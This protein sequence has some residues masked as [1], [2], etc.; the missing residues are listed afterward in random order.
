VQNRISS[1]IRLMLD[2]RV[3]WSAATLLRALSHPHADRADDVAEA[4]AVRD[5]RALLERF[6]DRYGQRLRLRG[7][8]LAEALETATSGLTLQAAWDP[9]AGAVARSLRGDDTAPERT[10]VLAGL[11][12]T[13]GGSSISSWSCFLYEPAR[14]RFG[15][16]LL[17]TAQLV[18]VSVDG[19]GVRVATRGPGGERRVTLTPEAAWRADGGELLPV[20]GEGRQQL[21]LLA[22]TEPG[23]GYPPSGDA[24]VAPAGPG[25]DAVASLESALALLGRAAPAYLRWVQWALRDLV[26]VRGEPPSPWSGTSAGWPGVMGLSAPHPPAVL[27][28]LL[29][30]EATH[31]YLHLAERVGPVDDG[32]DARRY[33]SP[34]KAAERP[35]GRLLAAYH[36]FGNVALLH[37]A[38]VEAETDDGGYAAG[39][40]ASLLPALRT[41]EAHL[42]ENPALTP[43]GRAL[44]QPLMARLATLEA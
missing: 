22:G 4:I 14:L 40:L 6:L 24:V 13:A 29:V 11:H 27:A 10:A 20:V 2:G 41:T 30:Y 26:V 36:A 31:Q 9:W 43:A 25:L 5:G 16:C 17:P 21:T 18:A 7:N 8:G 42:W 1:L 28:E 44:L 3:A 23:V 15:R 34:L 12:L 35:L 37:R 19:S 32:S 33:W 38:C 39:R